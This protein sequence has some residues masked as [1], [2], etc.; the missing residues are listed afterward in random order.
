MEKILEQPPDLSPHLDSAV[1]ALAMGASHHDW[2]HLDI[3][4]PLKQ[5]HL[6]LAFDESIYQKLLSSASSTRACALA[7]STALSHAGDWLNGVPSAA[8]GLHLQDS[9]VA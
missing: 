7:H 9:A 1:G 3:D 2:Q 5:H 8:L 4:V 6:S